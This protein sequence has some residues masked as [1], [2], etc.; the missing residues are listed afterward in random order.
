MLRS[1]SHQRKM[2]SRT[3]GTSSRRLSC[4]PIPVDDESQGSGFLH[5]LTSLQLDRAGRHLPGPLS[6]SIARRMPP[7]GLSDRRLVCSSRWASRHPLSWRRIGSR[8]QFLRIGHQ[9][10]K[11]RADTPECHSVRRLS[12]AGFDTQQPEPKGVGSAQE[13]VGVYQHV[14]C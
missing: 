12:S 9:A 1:T 5:C 3:W 2:H 14:R 11:H 4:A 13:I 6:L 8:L 10:C 7:I